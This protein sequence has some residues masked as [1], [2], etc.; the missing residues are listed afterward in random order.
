M[1]E[2]VPFAKNVEVN[3]ETVSTIIN[4]FPEYLTD[5]AFRILKLH[6]IDNPVP[7]KWYSQEAWL[8]AFKEI[9][10]ISWLYIH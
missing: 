9:S 4:A 6:G 10:D 3:G 7:G 2:F 1:A 5:M 8:N